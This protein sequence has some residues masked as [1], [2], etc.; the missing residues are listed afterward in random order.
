VVAVVVDTVVIVV[1]LYQS[2]VAAV[3]AQ[4]LRVAQVVA[5]VDTVQ[6]A[7][8]VRLHQAAVAVHPQEQGVV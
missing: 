4:E 6:V 3:A 2:E 5:L 1:V 7:H 8:R